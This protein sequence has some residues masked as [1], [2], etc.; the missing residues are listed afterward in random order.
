V[1][2]VAGRLQG[3][4]L[5]RTVQQQRVAVARREGRVQFPNSSS[6]SNRRRRGKSRSRGERGSRCKTGVL[7]R[8]SR[9]RMV[10]VEAIVGV[11]L[12]VGVR[13]RRQALEQALQPNTV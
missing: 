6:S 1:L 13:E 8:R 12:A 9:V 4:I 5:K 3:V 7:K 2:L 11:D 10:A